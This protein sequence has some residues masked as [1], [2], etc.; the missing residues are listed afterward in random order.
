MQLFANHGSA[1][2]AF[3]H[4]AAHA[5]DFGGMLLDRDDWRG[6]SADAEAIAGYW[7]VALASASDHL[8]A[9]GAGEEE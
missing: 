4:G 1:G 9:S 2:A 3:L 5:F 8:D 6:F 7:E